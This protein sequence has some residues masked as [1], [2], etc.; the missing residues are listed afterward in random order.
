MLNKNYHPQ[1]IN[2]CNKYDKYLNKALTDDNI[3]KYQESVIL[4]FELELAKSI[5]RDCGDFSARRVANIILAATEP[6]KQ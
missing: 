5:I 3:T 4:Y 6:Y 1:I 2:I